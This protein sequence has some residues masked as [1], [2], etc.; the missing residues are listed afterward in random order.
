MPGRTPGSAAGAAVHAGVGGRPPR[1]ELHGGGRERA[2]A[3][4]LVPVAA[5]GDRHRHAQREQ[6]RRV[7]RMSASSATCAR[8][9]QPDPVIPSEARDLLQP[10]ETRLPRRAASTIRHPYFASTA[11]IAGRSATIARSTAARSAVSPRLTPAAIANA[12]AAPGPS[13]VG[14][15]GVETSGTPVRG[16]KYPANG[17]QTMATSTSPRATASTSAR[18]DWASSSR[19]RCC[20]RPRCAR[21]PARASAV[22]GGGI[23]VVV[24][25]EVDADAEPPQPRIVERGDGR[26][27][28]RR[29]RNT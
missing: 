24:A 2:A 1:A 11:R 28:A 18:A 9:A 29:E 21:C 17:P 26:P 16:P 27:A 15:T 7:I 8:P 19:R 13:I 12:N 23:V 10:S 3:G 4:T 22:A 14:V 5:E 20:S 25:D 6:D